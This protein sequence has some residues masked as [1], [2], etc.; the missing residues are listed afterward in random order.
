MAKLPIRSQHMQLA[1]QIMDALVRKKS[2]PQDDMN[3][4]RARGRIK[5][6]KAASEQSNEK[7]KKNR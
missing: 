5:A 7:S 1:N 4:T 2:K 3:S 6:L